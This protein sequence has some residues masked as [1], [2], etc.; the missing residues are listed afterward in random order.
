MTKDRDPY[1]WLMAVS[2]F[3]GSS[4]LG[5]FLGKAWN[6]GPRLQN[7]WNLSVNTTSLKNGLCYFTIGE[8]QIPSVLVRGRNPNW[9]IDAMTW[10]AVRI[11]TDWVISPGKTY[12]NISNCLKAYCKC[13]QTSLTQAIV[14]SFSYSKAD[15]LCS[16]FY[17]SI[18]T[19]MR[20]YAAI[21]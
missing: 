8:K 11:L 14:I 18:C 19:I 21:L 1:N 2:V 20:R 15:L 4:G 9:R 13:F 3:Y 17:Q 10:C 7:T 5:R 6:R 12:G 16:T